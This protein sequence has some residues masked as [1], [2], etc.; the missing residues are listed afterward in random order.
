MSHQRFQRFD[1]NHFLSYRE[2]EKAEV[3]DR[4][5][6]EILQKKDEKI[7]ELHDLLANKTEQLGVSAIR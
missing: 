2:R 3:R 5:V 6:L 7:E 1:Y 4:K